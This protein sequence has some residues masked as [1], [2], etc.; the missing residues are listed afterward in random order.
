MK[1]GLTVVGQIIYAA[2]M[3]V[4]V[5]IDIIIQIQ[6]FAGGNF[7]GA[8]LYLIFGWTVTLTVGHWIGLLFAAPFAIAGME[9][10]D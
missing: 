1:K 2:V 5:V 4:V 9:R 3:L 10:D 7:G 8:V 6:L